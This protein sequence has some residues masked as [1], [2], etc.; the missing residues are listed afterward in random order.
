[1]FGFDSTD[2]FLGS[3]METPKNMFWMDMINQDQSR[4]H[5]AK[6]T[7]AFWFF[8]ILGF[9]FCIEKFQTPKKSFLFFWDLHCSYPF[10]KAK[11]PMFFYFSI[12]EPEKQNTRENQKTTLVWVKTKLSIVLIF[13]FAWIVFCLFFQVL[14]WLGHIGSGTSTSSQVLVRY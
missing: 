3:E 11:F 2:V 1:M 12:S 14:L 4:S 5:K 6:N 8:N 9:V 7:Q 13:C 10:K